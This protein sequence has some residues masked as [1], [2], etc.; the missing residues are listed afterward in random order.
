[1]LNYF[2]I[3]YLHDCMKPDTIDKIISGITN[4]LLKK[5]NKKYKY[6]TTKAM[7]SFFH[8]YVNYM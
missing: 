3:S 5:N 2:V 4:H 8:Q 7:L 6:Q 1:M